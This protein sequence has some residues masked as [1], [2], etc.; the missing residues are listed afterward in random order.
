[1]LNVNLIVLLIQTV[2]ITIQIF[3]MIYYGEKKS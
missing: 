2:L 1:M 3:L